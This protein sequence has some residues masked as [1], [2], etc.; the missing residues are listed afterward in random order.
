MVGTLLEN[1][2]RKSGSFQ[3]SSTLVRP[4]QE[5][6]F[7]GVYSDLMATLVPLNPYFAPH[8]C[9]LVAQYCQQLL[10]ILSERCN[11]AMFSTNLTS[12]LAEFM[13]TFLDK[14]GRDMLQHFNMTLASADS[15]RCKKVIGTLFPGVSSL[16]DKLKEVTVLKSVLPQESFPVLLQ[17]VFMVFRTFMK[18]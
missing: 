5:T 11:A 4:R 7:E 8:L 15:F 18:E 1:D 14:F 10:T 17:P 6:Q 9:P 3:S 13:D 12:S 16:L 2:Q